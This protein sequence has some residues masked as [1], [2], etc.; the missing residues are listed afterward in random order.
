VVEDDIE[1][2][3]PADKQPLKTLL[4]KKLLGKVFT[5]PDDEAGG[6][7]LRS[8][9]KRKREVEVKSKI[10][11]KVAKFGKTFCDGTS[12]DSRVD[13]WLVVSTVSEW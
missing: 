1:M 12:I 13:R 4:E 2:D 10:K 7:V 5:I 11:T 6:P 3:E 8:K 9:S